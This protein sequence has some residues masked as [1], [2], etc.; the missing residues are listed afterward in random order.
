MAVQINGTTTSCGD[1]DS[2]EGTDDDDHEIRKQFY[3]ASCLSPSTPP[4]SPQSIDYNGQ[5]GLSRFHVPS[6][7]NGPHYAN[8]LGNGGH[9]FGDAANVPCSVRKIKAEEEV[10]EN[11]KR[12]SIKKVKEEG[13]DSE[14]RPFQC[15]F[16]QKDFRRQYNLNAHLK[17]HLEERIHACNECPKTFLRPY[18]LSRHQRIHTL[19]KPY[20]CRICSQIFIRNDAIWRHYRKAHKGHPEVPTS[21]RDKKKHIGSSNVGALVTRVVS[22]AASNSRAKSASRKAKSKAMMAATLNTKLTDNTQI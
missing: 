15:E 4:L 6:F 14:L 7:S 13:N 11:K 18:D 12:T 16:C 1:N 2:I 21:R 20:K 17:T 5:G 8:D 9:T 10:D 19:D 22:A 3:E